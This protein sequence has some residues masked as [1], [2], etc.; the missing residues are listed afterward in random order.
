MTY[1]EISLFNSKKPAEDDDI[2]SGDLREIDVEIHNQWD[3]DAV[4]IRFDPA[5]GVRKWSKA[6]RLYMKHG[7]VMER[8]NVIER[9]Q[10]IPIQT[11]NKLLDLFTSKG[12]IQQVCMSCL[13]KCII[14]LSLLPFSLSQTAFDHFRWKD[15]QGTERVIPRL[16]R[17]ASFET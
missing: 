14:F 7:I 6:C 4:T 10:S 13:T 9:R 5:V 16:I 12:I 1:A 17:F 11:I 8:M 3:T 2:D 15:E